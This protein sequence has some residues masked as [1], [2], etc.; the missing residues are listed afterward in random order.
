MAR[1]EWTKWTEDDWEKI[2]CW[3]FEGWPPNHW[4]ELSDAVRCIE[5][6]LKVLPGEAQH[7]LQFEAIPPAVPWVGKVRTK[8]RKPGPDGRLVVITNKFTTEGE[9]IE[10]SWLIDAEF[11]FRGG[12][13]IQ[14]GGRGRPPPNPLHPRRAKPPRGVA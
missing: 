1:F 3:N 7:L 14:P 12:S 10:R 4:I 6:E 8:A 5:R 11:Y 13:M 9:V 2:N